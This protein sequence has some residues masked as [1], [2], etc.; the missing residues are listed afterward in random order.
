MRYNAFISYS[1]HA[2][3]S[4]APLLQ[5]AVQRFATPWYR[6]RSLRLFRDDTGLTMTHELW[7]AIQDALEDSEYFLLLA[8]PKSASSAWV[9]QEV[10]WWIENR[11][12]STLK[13]VLTEGDVV[14]DSESQDFDWDDT[15]ALPKALR[16]SHEHEPLWLDVR[17]LRSQDSISNENPDF[18]D[19]VAT[20]ASTLHGKPKDE[21]VGEDVRQ[22]RR[23]RRWAY[24]ATS[25][26]AVL[27]VSAV[28]AAIIAAIQTANVSTE[29]DRANDNALAA[30]NNAGTATA[31]ELVARTAQSEE[32]FQ[33]RNAE[34]AAT[35]EALAL[36]GEELQRKAAEDS[37]ATAVAERDLAVSRQISSHAVVEAQVQ[38]DLGLLLGM[39]ANSIVPT[40][41][42]ESA[43]FRLL[44]LHPRLSA[45][46][47]GHAEA[48][49]ALAFHPEGD[50]LV[51]AAEDE[52]IIFWDQASLKPIG[53][54][55]EFDRAV[56]SLAYSPDGRYLA[57]GARDSYIYVL[58]LEQDQITNMIF[59]GIAR[60]V[61][62]LVFSPDGQRLITVS[63]LGLSLWDLN[64]NELVAEPPDEIQQQ[65]CGQAIALAQDGQ[66]LATSGGEDCRWI[67]LWNPE[68]LELLG[69]FEGHS[70]IVWSLDF[71]QD[72][73]ILASGSGDGTSILWD[74]ASLSAVGNPLEG[75]SHSI[76]AVALNPAGSILATGSFD[77]TVI[78]WDVATQT[79]ISGVL[80]G[81]P[82][83]IT[84]LVFSPD[85]EFLI[86]GSSNGQAIVWST[87]SPFAISSEYKTGLSENTVLKPTDHRSVLIT[88]GA[89]IFSASFSDP[90]PNLVA[91]TDRLTITALEDHSGTNT[92][93]IGD[94]TGG[95]SVLNGQTNALQVFRVPGH[96]TSTMQ[97]MAYVG[98]SGP[99]ITA[100]F[101]GSTVL[102]DSEILIPVTHL[103]HQNVEALASTIDG[104]VFASIDHN[105][106][107]QV[108]DTNSGEIISSFDSSRISISYDIELAKNSKR[109]AIYSEESNLVDI[110]DITNVPVLLS[111]LN[112]GDNIISSIHLDQKAN[113]LAMG[114]FGDAIFL[115][116][117]KDLV[118]I[119]NFTTEGYSGYREIWNES[120]TIFAIT[121]KDVIGIDTR[122]REYTGV[123]ESN[124]LGL[125]ELT[126][127]SDGNFVAVILNDEIHVLGK[128]MDL[129]DSVSSISEPS[130]LVFEAHGHTL[131]ASD[132]EGQVS[133]WNAVTG[134]DNRR[135]Y[136]HSG[137]IYSIDISSDGKR[138][139]AVD[140]DRAIMWD[141]DTVLPLYSVRQERFIPPLEAIFIGDNTTFMTVDTDG[142]KEYSVSD[143]RLLV[144]Y[145]DELSGE[146]VKKIIESIDGKTIYAATTTGIIKLLDVDTLKDLE[147]DL[148]GH[149][150]NI[151]DI[152]VSPNG[153]LLASSAGD[154]SLIIWSTENRNQ[155]GPAIVKEDRLNEVIVQELMFSNDGSQL[156]TL[157]SKGVIDIWD[158]TVEGWL[159]AA[160]K[161]ANRELN[162]DEAMSIPGNPGDIC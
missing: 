22:H 109:I 51:T 141:L 124:Q 107:V 77:N 12:I 32:A 91:T 154:G 156:M 39:H 137:T 34:S 89:E 110:W 126:V 144:Q 72:G 90:V 69:A 68:T 56:V 146:W 15:T 158:L 8:S 33:R 142:I 87:S 3:S 60:Q 113:T 160:C 149:T 128:N 20:I 80:T 11:D 118:Q 55:V 135:S 9:D 58:D 64:S 134:G 19:V 148:I 63:D 49:T 162:R 115:Y 119:D 38:L 105:G 41:E 27:F 98:R 17:D 93:V 71:S 153:K 28:V 123:Y 26:L 82:G 23:N 25:V 130:Q 81:S 131:Y 150:K 86:S 43:L 125:E 5:H 133:S 2:D 152:A 79:R 116:D 76:D 54:P 132:S 84:E 45:F 40:F 157:D 127:S 88:D 30:N 161:I 151:V 139:I 4:F 46:L 67:Y 99:L 70:F 10:N 94:D 21:L 62:S 37:A 155:L 7:P 138:M 6:V 1:H 145:A 74:M 100:G 92:L 53:P 50:S 104:S 48:I 14:W 18:L 83:A 147:T 122:S 159:D 96:D 44:T 36:A 66:Y 73:S 29:R 140:K 117:M 65:V 111:T 57:A 85:G 35:A 101:Q 75:H 112:G 59:A 31:N 13:I 136:A 78:L 16:G 95:I 129:I 114:T 103:E 106:L 24:S 47:T 61:D 108:I 52:Q 121:Q 42:S 102:W 120:G 97:D 143:G